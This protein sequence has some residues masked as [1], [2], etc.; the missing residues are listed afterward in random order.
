[1]REID[2][3]ECHDILK[4]MAIAFDEICKR[5]QIPYYMIGGTMLGAIRHKGFI[6]WDDDMDFGIERR[7][8]PKLLCALSEELPSHLKIRTLENCE[9]VF[10]NFYKIEDTRTYAIDHWHENPTRL[11]IC[12]DIFPLDNGRNGF[13][14]TRMFAMYIYLLLIIKDYLYIDPI[15]RRGFKKWMAI[16][17]RKT[18]FVSIKKRLKYMDH[19]IFKHTNAASAYFVNYYGRWRTKEII[20]KKIFGTPQSY[21]FENI[22]LPGIEHSNAYLTAL[23]GN[24]MQ[25]PPLEKRTNHI[26]SK[27]FRNNYP[28]VYFNI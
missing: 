23:Y 27:Q 5:H 3:D 21:P 14:M 7:Y 8:I 2:I 17:L 1:M 28:S 11:G 6:P 25:L 13:F 26:K 18:N 12:I 24:Y 19:L 15:N 10:Y 22:I 4:S 16:V 20:S 9:Q